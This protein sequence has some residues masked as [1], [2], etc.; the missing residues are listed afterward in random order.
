MTAWGIIYGYMISNE[1]KSIRELSDLTG[2]PEGT[3]VKRKDNPREFRFWELS[4]ISAE[5][6][7]ST[8]DWHKLVD[9]IKEGK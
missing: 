5:L 7:M 8:D 6:K 1:I 3:L 2:I 9:A 4:Q